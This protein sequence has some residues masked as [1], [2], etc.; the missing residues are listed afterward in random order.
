M[1]SW[2]SDAERELREM[3]P[4][5]EEYRVFLLLKDNLDVADPYSGP[6]D[7]VFQYKKFQG[8]FFNG[9]VP[10]ISADFSV[11]FVPLPYDTSGITIMP[12]DSRFKGL[13][14]GIRINQR[15]KLFRNE[16]KVALLHEMI[17]ATGVTGHA[18][19]FRVEVFRLMSQGA[20]ITLTDAGPYDCIL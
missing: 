3:S 8:K 11:A 17:H 18:E 10:D 19:A 6:V 5:S 4:T 16:T 7:L 1:G 12:D 9:R 15:L 2:S 20:Y 14:C 13:G